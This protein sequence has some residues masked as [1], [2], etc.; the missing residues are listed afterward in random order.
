ML[1]RILRFFRIVGGFDR[2]EQIRTLG[3]LAHRRPIETLRPRQQNPRIRR[4]QPR[5]QRRR[6]RDGRDSHRQHPRHLIAAQPLQP[7]PAHRLQ[8]MMVLA[9][10]MKILHHSQPT[11]TRIHLREPT[12]MLDLA[13]PRRLR[14]P[15]HR[16]RAPLRPHRATHRSSRLIRLRNMIR[17]NT[18]RRI[19]QHPIP[20]GR[21][22]SSIPAELRRDRHIPIHTPRP[23]VQ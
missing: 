22:R 15:R 20:G 5:R 23:V 1:T 14:T 9:H 17:H 13:P 10:R 19:R 4:I 18:R 16:T 8:L 3:V 2:G 21:M 6:S 7:D 11:R 12:A